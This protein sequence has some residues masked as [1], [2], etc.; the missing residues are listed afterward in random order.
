MHEIITIQIGTQ[1]NYVGTHFWNAQESYF[2]YGNEQPSI[3]DHDIHFRSG[4]GAYG[5]DTFTPRTLIYDAKESFGTLR[6]RNALYEMQGEGHDP[7]HSIGGNPSLIRQPRIPQHPYQHHLDSNTTPPPLTSSDIRFWSDYNRVFY[8]PR[9]LQQLHIDSITA[10][11]SP[12]HSWSAGVELFEADDK[13]NDV[14]DRDFRYFAEEC[15][16]MQGV[17][18]MAGV[19]TAWGGFAS[20][21]A[22]RLRDELG[23]GVILVWG[24]HDPLSPA[25][26]TGERRYQRLGNSIRSLHTLGG[27][28]SIYAPLVSSAPSNQTSVVTD[29]SSAWE[30]SALQ[31]AVIETLS[32]PSRLRRSEPGHATLADLEQLFTAVSSNRKTVQ[33][34]ISTQS[35]E[36]HRNGV[37]ANGVSHDTD[38]RLSTTQA[39]NIS[40]D[41]DQTEISLFP[42]Q[43][44]ASTRPSRS[45]LFSR[46]VVQRGQSHDTPRPA[47]RSQNPYEATVLQLSNSLG[48]PA[49][50]SSYPRIFQAVQGS[51]GD[52]TSI[53]LKASLSSTA[54]VSA[55]MRNMADQSR[56]LLQLDER[57]DVSSTLRT[58]AD[59][60]IEGWDSADESGSDED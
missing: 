59:E 50:L 31:Q 36:P 32:L 22:E 1:S 25:D 55:W 49:T 16:Q 60:Y 44:A 54:A 40:N 30:T 56:R 23:K 11:L 29:A 46:L 5:S 45:H 42:P 12:I 34:G 17:M 21:Y 48:F 37:V 47:A 3:V 58:W 14:L 27:Q 52:N 51:S 53:A 39:V 33:T 26:N 18:L 9:S 6:Q 7:L 2:T 35:E 10:S 8:H 28:A 13:E 15:D 4:I 38:E 20:R 43:S 41:T 19:E 57:E 24:L